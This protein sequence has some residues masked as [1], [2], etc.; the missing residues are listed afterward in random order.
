MEPKKPLPFREAAFF[1][2]WE[3]QIRLL[4]FVHCS[5]KRSATHGE[6]SIAGKFS[7]GL[8]DIYRNRGVA[9]MDCCFSSKP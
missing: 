3:R 8:K 6:I 2:L 5:S 4:L 1:G 9:L 7:L